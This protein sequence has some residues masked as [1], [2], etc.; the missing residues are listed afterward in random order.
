MIFPGRSTVFSVR[1]PPNTPGAD[2]V[3]VS[4]Y[5]PD[6]KH[7]VGKVNMADGVATVQFS[8]TE[9]K[10]FADGRRWFFALTKDGIPVHQE[11]LPVQDDVLGDDEEETVIV[12]TGR[13]GPI[14]PSG[15]PGRDGVD[16]KKGLDGAP[17]PKGDPGPQGL[18]GNTGPAG[19]NGTDG[20]S[21]LLAAQPNGSK[22]VIAVVGWFGGTG[23]P[24]TV[25]GFLGPSGIVETAIEATDFRGAAMPIQAAGGAAPL[26]L[27]GKKLGDFSSLQDGDLL[28]YSA[29]QDRWIPVPASEAGGS[30]GSA[31]L[32]E[33]SGNYIY[34]ATA[35]TDSAEGDAV[36]RITRITYSNGVQTATGVA[37][38][39]TW[40]GRAGHTYT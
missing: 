28:G 4:S 17:G 20:W 11:E 36:W 40:T 19:E 3:V 29:V 30:Q 13:R 14:G 27:A 23:T 2:T 24:P 15:P 39:V 7:I 34:A 10:L 32:Y 31:R 1:V 37:V 33:E 21:P 16:G 35:P 9:T 8:A 26:K 25:T 38:A 22:L 18:P 12:K 6:E 5:S